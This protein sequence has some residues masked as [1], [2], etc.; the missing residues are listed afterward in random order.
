MKVLTGFATALLVFGISSTTAS[1]QEVCGQGKVYPRSGNFLFK[2]QAAH[3]KTHSVV[4][5]P[6]NNFDPIKNTNNISS[7][8]MHRLDTGKQVRRANLKS[9]GFCPGWGE[10]LN[11]PT[12]VFPLTGYAAQRK[13]QD[14][15]FIR[16][17]YKKAVT[18]TLDGLVTKVKCEDFVIDNPR[19]RTPCDITSITRKGEYHHPSCSLKWPSCINSSTN[20]GY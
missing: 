4:I 6:K 20:P 16:L 2:P 3:F 10:C 7:V 14:G 5:A 11:A 13:F 9:T 19:C 17:R 8:T 15:I 12:Y 1:A 18:G